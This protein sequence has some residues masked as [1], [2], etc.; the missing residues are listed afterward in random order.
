MT[1]VLPDPLDTDDDI[2]YPCYREMEDG[3]WTC[4][5]DH[6]GCLWNNGHNE[7]SHGGNSL[8]PLEEVT[9]DAID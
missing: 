7:C 1:V 5:N 6:T 9:L 8:S 2:I 4:I 3:S